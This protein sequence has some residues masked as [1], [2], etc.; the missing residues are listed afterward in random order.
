MTTQSSENE[1]GAD[2]TS[3]DNTTLVVVLSTGLSVLLV[4]TIVVAVYLRSRR[5][6]HRFG[7][8]FRR[9]VTPIGDDEIATW[10]LNQPD[11]KDP[12]EYTT[13]ASHTP[14][15]STSTRKA[16][17]VIQY[18]TGGRLSEEI[19]SPVSCSLK[20]SM[21]F[22]IPRLPPSAVL[23]VAPNARTGL[24]DETVPGD[25]PF[26]PSPRRNHSRLQKTPPSSPR[27]GDHQHRA[28][29]SRS[30][31]IRSL[32]AAYQAGG[33][34]ARV[35]SEQPSLPGRARV[36]ASSP[37]PPRASFGDN[38]AFTGLTPPP[39]RRTPAEEI[40]RALG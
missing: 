10:R 33:D 28:K 16:A 27:M 31:S 14:N 30:S 11:E 35:S 15:A 4:M 37:N 23:A 5:R 25:Q 26:L 20:K 36:Y 8:L 12:E 29:G 7:G 38:G 24:T 3:S 39:S 13:R 9:G 1:A 40:G 34:S 21:S 2:G 17:S 18:Q 19:A 22:D 32:S 6:Q